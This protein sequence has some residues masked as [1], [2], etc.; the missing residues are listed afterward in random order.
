MRI[1]DL[2]EISRKDVI[3]L[4]DGK[5]LGYV[6]DVRFTCEGRVVSIVVPK[7]SSMFTFGK[8]ENIVIPFEKIECIGQDAILVRVSLDECCI[9][10]CEKEKG[11]RKRGI[12]S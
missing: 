9:D 5:C 12:F 2:C 8:S 10:N 7:N 3:N 1:Y 6:S 4:C 11:G